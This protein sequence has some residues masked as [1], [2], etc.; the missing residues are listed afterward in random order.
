MQELKTEVV[1]WVEKIHKNLD[2]KQSE[3]MTGNMKMQMEQATP[4]C[5][6]RVHHSHTR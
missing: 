4:M 6:L 3:Y 2:A 1:R 5:M